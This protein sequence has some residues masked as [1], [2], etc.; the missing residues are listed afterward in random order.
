ML[1]AQP[2]LQ[3]ADFLN[4]ERRM[5]DLSHCEP[6]LASRLFQKETLEADAP[7]VSFGPRPTIR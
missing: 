5:P 6:S 3:P 4:F 7:Q 2:Q 1:N